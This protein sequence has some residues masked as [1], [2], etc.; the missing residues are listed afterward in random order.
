MTLYLFF[1]LQGAHKQFKQT[2]FLCEQF[3]AKQ[4]IEAATK[5]FNELLLTIVHIQAAGD[6]I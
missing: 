1:D 5:H 6:Y 4:V 3:L 2:C